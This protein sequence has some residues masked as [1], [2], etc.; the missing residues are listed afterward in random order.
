M[1]AYW[2][3]V[4]PDQT[5]PF[6]GLKCGIECGRQ[7]G[8]C[9]GAAPPWTPVLKGKRRQTWLSYAVDRNQPETS[10]AFLCWS[11]METRVIFLPV[12]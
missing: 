10:Y 6:E 5:G 11:L 8:A 3:G 12:A 2:K 9:I 7:N 4:S 1:L